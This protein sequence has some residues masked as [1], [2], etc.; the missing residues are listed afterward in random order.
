MDKIAGK[1]APTKI[2]HRPWEV[3]PWR[4]CT[5]GVTGKPAPASGCAHKKRP[6]RRGAFDAANNV[7]DQTDGVIEQVAESAWQTVGLLPGLFGAKET[8]A[9]LV[10]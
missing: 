5:S 3:A 8:E 10:T 6:L 2:G 4:Q 7:P 1:P 9:E